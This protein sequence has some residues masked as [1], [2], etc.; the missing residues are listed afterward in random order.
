MGE[1]TGGKGKK[2]ILTFPFSVYTSTSCSG[3]RNP[4]EKI[5]SVSFCIKKKTGPSWVLCKA[6]FLDGAP[7]RFLPGSGEEKGGGKGRGWGWCSTFWSENWKK[8]F[9]TGSFFAEKG[10]GFMS[11]FF[12]LGIGF[13]KCCFGRRI[14]NP[15]S[16]LIFLF[17]SVSLVLFNQFLK[18][19]SSFVFRF[20]FFCAVFSI[21]FY[22][23][24]KMPQ[25]NFFF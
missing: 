22:L 17:S 4:K 15:Y 11:N 6:M 24:S 2:K 8:K 9:Q 25:S 7:L 3:G 23:V 13:K 18:T 5:G 1:K 20:L 10:G 19:C 14:S 16:L 21:S 12:G